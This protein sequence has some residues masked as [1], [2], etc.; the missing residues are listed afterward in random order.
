MKNIKSM[1]VERYEWGDRNKPRNQSDARND[2][3][4]GNPFDESDWYK[5]GLAQ[6]K[7]TIDKQPLIAG[8]WDTSIFH[9]GWEFID[10]AWEKAYTEEQWGSSGDTLCIYLKSFFY[11]RWKGD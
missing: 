11:H 6:E 9:E 1:D 5:G 4:W 8:G 7:R 10:G 2:W 3:E